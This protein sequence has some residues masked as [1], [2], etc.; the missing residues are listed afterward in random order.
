MIRAKIEMSFSLHLN[1]ELILN[2]RISRK[3]KS[4]LLYKLVAWKQI[5]I[6]SL[7]A[8]C[9]GLWKTASDDSDWET[10]LSV[11]HAEHSTPS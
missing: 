1:A 10:V 8:V 2:N 9:Q 4:I 6:L 11:S 3:C 5:F 7:W